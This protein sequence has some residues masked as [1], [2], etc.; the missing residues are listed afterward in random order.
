MEELAVFQ[1]VEAQDAADTSDSGLI[2]H[3]ERHTRDA[4]EVSP[5]RRSNAARFYSCSLR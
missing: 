3:G 5:R 4:L 2:P 1:V